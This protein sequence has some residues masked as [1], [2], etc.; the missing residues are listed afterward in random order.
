MV[1]LHRDD[2][3]PL[4]VLATG[5]LVAIILGEIGLMVANP[6][7][8]AFTVGGDLALYRD[9][10]AGWLHGQPFYLPH[11]LAGP[12]QITD[13]DRLYPPPSLLL[14]VPFTV[15][16]W[17]LW[18]VLPLGAT[19]WMLWRLRP[20]VLIWPA[21]ALCVAW[22]DTLIK[23]AAGNPVMWSLGF[24]SLGVLYDWPAVLAALKLSLFPFA[25]WG[26]W[27][28][29]WWIAAVVVGAVSLAFLPMWPDFIRALLNSR[30]GGLLYSWQDAPMLL[31][32]LLARAGSRE[33]G[34][35]R[36]R[37]GLP[38]RF[39]DLPVGGKAR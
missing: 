7:R 28:R 39:R 15:L 5:V 3:R 26:V 18:W 11:Q 23:I 13:G 21:L 30:G 36:V 8:L 37:V 31:I 25:L 24:L 17:A 22:P 29:S 12:Y 1:T 9:A 33:R 20:S 6:G 19:G 2:P 34:L 32:P 14:F 10:A 27:R 16:P 38:R 35:P 4:A